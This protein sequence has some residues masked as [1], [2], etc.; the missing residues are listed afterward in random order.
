VNGSIYFSGDTGVHEVHGLI[1]G[2][3]ARNN[4]AAGSL[5]MPLTDERDAKGDWTNGRIS[6]FYGGYIVW[7]L[8]TAR[9]GTTSTDDRRN[10]A[11]SAQALPLDDFTAVQSHINSKADGL[12]WSTD[13][14]SSPGL[15]SVDKIFLKAC[16][17]HDFG[18]RNFGPKHGN[19]DPS[20]TSLDRVNQTFLADMLAICAQRG[21]SGSC[22]AAANS[23]YQAVYLNSTA[24][25]HWWR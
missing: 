3:Y 19:L 9:I 24:G 22:R 6:F 11:L 14:C 5:G 2:V 23:Y 1:G 25:K 15:D 17:R 20:A 10:E 13:G 4:W 7:D 16:V 12:D 8:R 18:N 21:N